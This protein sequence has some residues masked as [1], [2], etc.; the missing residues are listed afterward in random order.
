M[1]RWPPVASEMD[2]SAQPD[3]WTNPG[4]NHGDRDAVAETTRRPGRKRN[5]P[6]K[7]QRDKAGRILQTGEKQGGTQRQAQA[8]RFKQLGAAGVLDPRLGS[9]LGLMFVL[10]VPI[11]ISAA[12]YD[13]ASWLADKLR[14]HDDVVLDIRRSPSSNAIERGTGG[15]GEDALSLQAA[16]VRGAEVEA[17]ASDR[18][19]LAQQIRAEIDRARA[20]MGAG[21]QGRLRWQALQAA[22]RSE[23]LPTT[24]QLSDFADAV[25]ALATAGG[26]YEEK[27]RRSANPRAAWG[28]D[29]EAIEIIRVVQGESG[30]PKSR[31]RRASTDSE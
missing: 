9:T 12:E 31:R 24:D 28:H 11:K 22:C 18:R 8:Q 16:G 13:A 2:R 14:A 5:D 17:A 10:G 23:G 7:V 1:A 6:L 29:A 15:R 27:K 4:L 26:Y 19:A 30:V 25:V 20:A 3:R 21:V